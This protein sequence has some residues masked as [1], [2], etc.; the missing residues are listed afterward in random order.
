MKLKTKRRTG[1]AM[2]CVMTF[3]AVMSNFTVLDVF[4]AGGK[5]DVWDFGGVQVKD[6]M[7]QNHISVSTLDKL[8]AVGDGSEA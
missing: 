1:A 8:S 7:Y 6:G 4:G 2:A 3:C 5:I